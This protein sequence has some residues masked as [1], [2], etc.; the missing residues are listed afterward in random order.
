VRPRLLGLVE[1]A[2]YLGL[3]TWTTRT[4]IANGVL[5]CVRLPSLRR[6][7][8][9]MRRVLIDVRDLDELIER[10]S[11]RVRITD[12]DDRGSAGARLRS[13]RRSSAR[14]SVGSRRMAGCRSAV[15]TVTTP[16]PLYGRWNPAT[17]QNVET[18]SELIHGSLPESAILYENAAAC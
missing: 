2:A 5:R 1:A 17:D 13:K 14:R 12:D 4:L 10:S 9:D 18:Q 7:G 16:L 8:E 3:S 15:R 6:N 11:S